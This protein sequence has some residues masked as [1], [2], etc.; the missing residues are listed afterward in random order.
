MNLQRKRGRCRRWI[1]DEFAA[2]RLAFRKLKADLG[3]G[4]A[5]LPFL[6]GALQSNR[7]ARETIFEDVVI[8]AVLGALGSGIFPED[9]GDENEWGLVARLAEVREGVEAGP[10]RQGVG[11]KDSGKALGRK[12]GLKVRALMNND[13]VDGNACAAKFVKDSGGVFL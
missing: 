11:G 2:A 12:R 1:F 3:V 8:Y 7:E 6:Q 10:T 13:G 5:E 4:V 9:P